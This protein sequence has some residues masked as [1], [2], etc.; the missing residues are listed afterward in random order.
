MTKLSDVM[1]RDLVAFTP[2]TSL[3]DAIE[4][5]AERHISGAP[6]LRG[7]RVVGVLTAS[8]IL[9]FVATNPTAL[10]DFGDSDGNDG[11][12]A[13]AGRT[14]AEAMSG[15]PACTLSSDAPVQAAADLMRKANIHRVFVVEHGRLIGV[16]SSL[17][18]TR[19]L[20]DR[21]IVTRTFVFPGPAR[22]D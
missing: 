22:T 21:K 14:V 15:G 11:R 20:A 4:L 2:E 3:V 12:N 1:S 9:E 10:A 8:D 6:V 18:I 17:D 16:V 19:A 5:L 7:G 13:L